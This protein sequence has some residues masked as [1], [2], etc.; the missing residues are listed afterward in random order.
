LK[1][2]YCRILQRIYVFF[3]G[4]DLFIAPLTPDEDEFIE[5]SL[6]LFLKRRIIKKRRII[7]AKTVLGIILADNYIKQEPYLKN[8]TNFSRRLYQTAFLMRYLCK[9]I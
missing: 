1:A 7:D 2:I 5:Q 8:K 9:T 4:E 3:S 6:P